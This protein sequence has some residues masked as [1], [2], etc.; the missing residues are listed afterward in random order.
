MGPMILITLL[1]FWITVRGFLSPSK[2]KQLSGLIEAG[3][4][5]RYGSGFFVIPFLGQEW[6][7]GLRL[8]SVWGMGSLIL[9]ALAQLYVLNG[10]G[11]NQI[12][13]SKRVSRR[14]H[15][16]IFTPVYR[17]D[18]CLCGSW[19]SVLVVL[20]YSFLW[21]GFRPVCGR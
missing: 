2:G 1:G 7:S 12:Y 16:A 6:M 15:P 5:G 8:Y 11:K 9:A 21:V 3:T 4:C 20:H 14:T 18:L 10:M 13:S 17:F 19:C